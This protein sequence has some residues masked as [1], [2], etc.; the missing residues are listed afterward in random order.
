MVTRAQ[1][2]EEAAP[3]LHEG[4]Q[5]LDLSTGYAHVNRMGIKTTR[6]ATILVTDRRVVIISKKAGGNEVQDYAYG[7]LTGVDFKTGFTGGR[8]YIRASGD[9][10]SVGWM[11]KSEIERIAQ[12]IR[13]K[14]AAAHPV[15]VATAEL[16]PAPDFAEE[17]RKLAA[18]RDD[19][20]LTEGEFQA[21]RSRLLES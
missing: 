9:S 2:L 13:H 16:A 12:A 6:P 14:M 18:L 11:D 20:L 21:R 3:A 17:M 1:L 8:I 10:S 15:G 5:V 7:L 4:E 19:G